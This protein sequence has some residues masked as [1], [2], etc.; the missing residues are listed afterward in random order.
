MIELIRSKAWAKFWL[1]VALIL[2]VES[3][4]GGSYGWMWMEL[5][6]AV[7]WALDLTFWEQLN[8]ESKR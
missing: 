2:A 6:C 5:A 3:Y 4:F 8:R 7:Y 1:I